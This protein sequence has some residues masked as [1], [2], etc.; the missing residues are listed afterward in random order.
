MLT[1][2]SP[3]DVQ[4]KHTKIDLKNHQLSMLKRCKDIESS[5]NGVGIMKDPPG[6]GKTY[7]ILSLILQDIGTKN[8]NILVVPQNIY[9]QWTSA[10]I[11]FSDDI[12]YAKY[13]DYQ[14]ASSL[15]FNPTFKSINLVITT[16]L[17]FN[18]MRDALESNKVSVNR[19]II[20]E[21]DSVTF[22]FQKPLK[23]KTLW[24]VSAS[25][26]QLSNTLIEK[27]C[28]GVH[29]E[30]VTCQCTPEFV[31][32][33]F[34]LPA[35]V[36]K[37]IIC[38]S[39]LLDNILFGI[40]N[41]YEMQAA[42]AFDY[43]KIEQQHITMV[44]TTEKEALEYLMKDLMVTID[45]EEKQIEHYDNTMDIDGYANIRN[46]EARK[47]SVEKLEKSKKRL[48]SISDR[49][50]EGNMC[51]ICYEDFNNESKV[52]TACCQ[53]SFCQPCISNW[54][55][56][57]LIGLGRQVEKCPYCRTLCKYEDHVLLNRVVDVVFESVP[58]SVPDVVPDTVPS[59]VT[60]EEPMRKMDKLKH[61]LMNE[62][63]HKVIIFSDFSKVFK[64]VSKMLTE[65][66]IK[67]TEL[68][69]GN[70]AN[71]DKDIY[72]YKLG[73]TRVL[74]CNSQFFGCGM[75]LEFTTD[76]IFL[77]QTNINMYN[78]VIGRAQRPG[79][80]APL[81]VFRLLHNNEQ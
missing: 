46:M 13:I 63:G 11:A 34:P 72:N 52:I 51:L 35:F 73:D 44:A 41:A 50:N 27:F 40:L 78:Q 24:M 3:M 64:E 43:S 65:L 30:L 19:V 42:N 38:T 37:D 23:C 53:N 22:L 9:T 61:L 55:K 15:Y 48:K 25:F 39:T 26:D 74:M 28:P 5:N 17:Y 75:N 32:T 59:T 71:I 33:G 69:G 8:I 36:K 21:I 16:P 70:I 56:Q 45:N 10:I 1:A 7:V 81:N 14:E 77:H 60:I 76:I 49:L 80:T 68:D 4:P 6:A 29:Q 62:I 31:L 47:V 79:R 12:S 54:Y 18:I 2:L 57:T 67:F 20:D 58:Q 66:N